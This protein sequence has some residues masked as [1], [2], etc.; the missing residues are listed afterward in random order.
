MT[1]RSAHHRKLE[2]MYLGA[3]I[4]RYFRPRI[5]IGDGRAA[6][7]IPIREEFFH[8]AHAAHGAI[9][10]KALDDAAFFAANSLVEDAFVLTVSFNIHLTRPI[11]SGEI[12]ATAEVVHNSR[13][14]L[15]AE[16]VAVDAEGR[17]VAR[18]TGMFMR[19]DTPLSPD[20]GYA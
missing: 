20:L 9:Y 15:I 3:P 8:A 11:S 12:R 7:S 14:L 19:S 17:E 5:E 1:D 6:V 13:R 18:G 2:R 4:N 10:F 16:A